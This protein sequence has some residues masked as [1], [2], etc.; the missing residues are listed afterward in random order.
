MDQIDEILS[1]IEHLPPE[2]KILAPLLLALADLESDLSRIVDMISFEPALTSRLLHICNSAFFGL[3]EPVNA[4]SEA[5]NR[6]GFEIVYFIAAV[7]SGEKLFI[8]VNAG[9]PE[10]SLL[11]RHAVT[12]AFACQF[13]AKGIQ[14]DAGLLFTT[15]LLHDL[16]KLVLSMVYKNSYVEL[17]SRPKLMGKA[18]VAAEQSGFGLDHAE[19]GARLLERWKFSEQFVALVRFHHRPTE[20][21]EWQRL[22]ACVSLANFLAHGVEDSSGN[23]DLFPEEAQKTL[24]LVGLAPCD[25]SFYR[26][27]LKQS[28]EFIDAICRA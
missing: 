7:A 24:E 28:M 21:L 25:L 17:I 13:V 16:G 14:A 19:V 26:N 15:G 27:E 23:P 20:T 10:G 5:V 18:L 2:P 22:A 12:T 9:H 3:A 6:L 4:V 1:E 8:P 11:W